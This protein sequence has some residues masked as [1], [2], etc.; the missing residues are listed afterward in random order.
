MASN[1]Q[2]PPAPTFSVRLWSHEV[3]IA[4]ASNGPK[5]VR[6]EIYRM[7]NGRIF[8]EYPPAPGRPK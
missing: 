5:P 6:D 4:Q 8:H 1:P 3:A 7:S 2:E